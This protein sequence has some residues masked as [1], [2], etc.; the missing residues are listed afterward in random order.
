MISFTLV[1]LGFANSS[2]YDY[3]E[4]IVRHSG[5]SFSFIIKFKKEKNISE[6]LQTVRNDCFD[7]IILDRRTYLPFVNENG[8]RVFKSFESPKIR[9]NFIL[10]FVKKVIL[11]DLEKACPYN[12]P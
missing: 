1:S 4:T 9:E 7:Y 6:F 3:F 8:K 5:S 12:T 10:L 2:G 11:T